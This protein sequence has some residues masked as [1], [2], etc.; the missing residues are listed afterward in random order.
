[1]NPAILMQLLQAGAASTGAF[2]NAVPSIAKTKYE[3]RNE[4]EMARLG[5]LLNTGGLG[6]SETERQRLLAPQQ[7][8]AANELQRA[9]NESARLQSLSGTTGAG[10]SLKQA[11]ALGAAGAKTRADINQGIAGLDAQKA[12][13]QRQ[14]Y[15]SRL[16]ADSEA[17]QRRLA[18][19]M[20]I[21]AAGAETFSGATSLN[22]TVQPKISQADINEQASESGLSG[23]EMNDLA[24]MLKENPE[25]QGQLS[26]LLS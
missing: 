4:E 21:P 14:E 23:E 20:S 25:L 26:K 3:R 5:D 22:S 1:M 8:G 9:A 13:M 2:F 16:G 10:S 11:A 7:E 19:W 17:K 15:W 18:A 12:E 24:R 6:L